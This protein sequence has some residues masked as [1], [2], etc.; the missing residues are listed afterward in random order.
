MRK[1]ISVD[2]LEAAIMAEVSAYSAK[3]AEAAKNNVKSVA[4]QCAQELKSISPR[5]TGGYASGWKH[6]VTFE[7]SENIRVRVYNAKRPSITYLLEDGHA[8][9][10][11][12]RVEGKPHI[13][14]AKR[15]AEKRLLNG[16]RVVIKHA[17]K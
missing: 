10:N 5:R 16:E 12:G 13:S 4:K 9:I 17:S 2:S 11:G 7:S 8:K 6:K 15:N 1:S 3:L 14:V